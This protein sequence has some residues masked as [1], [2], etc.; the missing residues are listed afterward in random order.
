MRNKR[1]ILAAAACAFGAFA[2]FRAACGAPDGHDNPPISVHSGDWS[3]VFGGYARMGAALE[4]IDGAAPEGTENHKAGFLAL[5][6]RLNFT[7]KYKDLISGRV[8]MDGAGGIDAMNGDSSG[9]VSLKDAYLDFDVAPAFRVKIGQFKPPTDFESMTSTPDLNFIQ[10]SVVSAGG[11]S[12]L[13][14]KTAYN[15]GMSPG[16]QIG[17]SL[18]S[19]MLEYESVGFEYNASATNGRNASQKT[20]EA[21]YF[22]AYGRLALGLKKSLYGDASPGMFFTMALG[23]AYERR[24]LKIDGSG[25]DGLAGNRYRASAEFHANYEGFKADAEAIWE[26][27]EVLESDASQITDGTDAGN[28]RKA[29]IDKLGIVAQA[30]YTLPIEN[31]RFQLG[32]RFAMMMPV[33]DNAETYGSVDLYQHTASLGYFVEKYPITVRVDYTRNDEKGTEIHNDTLYGL[34]QVRW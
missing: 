24:E 17:I 11:S 34:V 12:E 26:R 28:K 27:Y 13:H 8:S 19:D 10:K 9:T 20:A 15:S 32:Y 31:F 3:F 16:R 6:G 14:T 1:A 23:G 30:S 33:M 18:Y 5:N 22:A 21:G 7:L 4:S 25:A 29:S 2:P